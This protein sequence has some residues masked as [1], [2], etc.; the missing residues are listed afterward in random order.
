MDTKFSI[1]QFTSPEHPYIAFPHT[2]LAVLDIYRFTFCK[3]DY[4]PGSLQK[5]RPPVYE[6]A[7]V[8]SSACQQLWCL[9]Q[10]RGPSPNEHWTNL[11]LHIP[12]WNKSMPDITHKNRRN[13]I[14]IIQRSHVIYL[15]SNAKN[16]KRARAGMKDRRNE[17]RQAYL[18]GKAYRHDMM[19]FT[20]Q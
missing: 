5:H 16:M 17:G 10:L 11:Q 4:T 12:K 14:W 2:N 3:V 8:N 1:R 15:V 13:K 18:F 20:I 6:E 19:V 9:M 7:H